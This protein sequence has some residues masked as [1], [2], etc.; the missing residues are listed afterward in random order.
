MEASGGMTKA[1]RRRVDMNIV[2]E[3]QCRKCGEI[4]SVVHFYKN[5]TKYGDGFQKWC[6]PCLKEY[7]RVNKDT[8][9]QKAHLAYIKNIER[10]KARRKEYEIKNKEK[11]K[12]SGRKWRAENAEYIKQYKKERKEHYN[13]L[14]RINRVKNPNQNRIIC[15]RRRAR[16]VNAFGNHTAQEWESILNKYNH[17]CLRCGTT[18]RITIDHVLPLNKGGSNSIENIQPLCIYCNSSKQDAYEDYRPIED[19][20]PLEQLIELGKKVNLS[21]RARGLPGTKNP[22]VKLT[23][24]KVIEI[25]NSK[26][27]TKI[28]SERYGLSVCNINKI[29]AGKL[30]KHLNENKE[31]R[32]TRQGIRYDKR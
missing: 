12:E 11:L 4:K 8:I 6:I 3:K 9:K 31:T 1:H 15:N 10:N 17:K 20:T 19:R 21:K 2:T 32:P 13:Q 30:W 16:L 25:I 22:K 28:L 7:N 29:R 18:E 14:R 5:N 23:D 26:E 27:P 24:D